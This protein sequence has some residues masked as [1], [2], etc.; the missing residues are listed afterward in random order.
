MGTILNYWA[1]KLMGQEW[2][3]KVYA[4]P[5]LVM[6]PERQFHEYWSTDFTIWQFDICHLN[7]VIWHLRFDNWH[8]AI[9]QFR[10]FCC[11]QRTNSKDTCV[12][13]KITEQFYENRM[14]IA[15]W[16]FCFRSW[17]HWMDKNH[18]I[19]RKRNAKSVIFPSAVSVLAVQPC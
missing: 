8:L 1:D 2:F 19:H 3:R 12:P 15:K 18:Q 10:V 14:L 4:I 13:K 16:S 5:S 17:F 6:Q 7:L 11:S 9:T